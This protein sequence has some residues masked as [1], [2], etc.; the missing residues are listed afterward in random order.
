VKKKLCSYVYIF[1]VE[2]LGGDD[3]YGWIEYPVCFLVY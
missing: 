3:G 2:L 1:L